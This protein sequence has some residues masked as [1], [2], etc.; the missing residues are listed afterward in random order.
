MPDIV[1][2]SKSSIAKLKERIAYRAGLARSNRFYVDFSAVKEK[3]TT[4]N[5]SDFD[6]LSYFCETS[7]LPG[8]TTNTVDYGSWHNEIKVPIGYSND[9]V[10]MS[11]IMTNDY[12]VKEILDKWSGLIINSKTYLLNYD[13]AY[14]ADVKIY[15]LDQADKITYGVI[16]RGA[17]P[18]SV[19]SIELSNSEDDSISKCSAS[20]AY[21]DFQTIN[22]S[23]KSTIL[24]AFNAPQTPTPRT[25]N[26][27]PTNNATFMTTFNTP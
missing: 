25:P 10:E 23:V 21:R 3:L 27:I 6:D 14:R 17:Y 18:Y 8:R 4:I 9:D 12:F 15:Q 1:N 19:K 20:F 5:I 22:T 2:T 11:F 16:L 26:L 13:D 24:S 7:S